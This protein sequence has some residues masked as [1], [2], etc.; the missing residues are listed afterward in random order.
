MCYFGHAE[1]DVMSVWFGSLMSSFIRRA[2]AMATMP[3]AIGDLR[4]IMPPY[5]TQETYCIVCFDFSLHFF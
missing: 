1:V 5:I 3:Q 2:D 4:P